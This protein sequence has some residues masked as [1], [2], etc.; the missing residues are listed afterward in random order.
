MDS[1]KKRS[2]FQKLSLFVRFNQIPRVQ[3]LGIE[4]HPVLL[5]LAVIDSKAGGHEGL[6]ML[7]YRLHRRVFRL[8]GGGDG[9]RLPFGDGED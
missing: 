7:D 4:Q 8:I 5:I 6:R 2:K 9:G 1:V 3:G